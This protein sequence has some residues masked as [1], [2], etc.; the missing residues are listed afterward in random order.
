MSENV[1][2]FITCWILHGTP[3]GF[4]SNATK[5][6]PAEFKAYANFHG[7][8]DMHIDHPSEPGEKFIKETLPNGDIACT[9]VH[10]GI[11]QEDSDRDGSNYVALTVFI[12]ENV[13]IS[14]EKQFEQKLKQILGTNV[15][16]KYTYPY[17]DSRKWVQ[18]T[19]FRLFDRHE[20]DERISESLKQLLPYLSTGE[21]TRAPKATVKDF[22]DAT[23]KLQAEIHALEQQLAAKRAELERL[24]KQA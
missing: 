6:D 7:S 21:Q 9:F 12:P 17:G 1:Q 14:N 4:K 19:Q 13:K 2:Q 15:L 8:E 18:S 20:M 24:T 11:Y 22:D 16:D 23:Q 3:V 10:T 5:D